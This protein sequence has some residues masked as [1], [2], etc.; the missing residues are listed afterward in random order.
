M[1]IDGTNPIL[2]Y[3]WGAAAADPSRLIQNLAESSKKD[4]QRG[5]F[6][7]MAGICWNPAAG[8]F[9]KPQIPQWSMEVW[10]QRC[11]TK[12][13]REMWE[14]DQKGDTTTKK[15]HIPEISWM[16]SDLL[17]NTHFLLEK[18]SRNSHFLLTPISAQIPGG[19]ND[20]SAGPVKNRMIL[21]SVSCLIP[22]NLPDRWP[23]VLALIFS[24]CRSCYLQLGF[25]FGL[26]CGTSLGSADGKVR[27]KNIFC[28]GIVQV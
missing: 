4:L 27:R 11:D 19:A 13:R 9:V 12:C 28:E 2:L 15:T 25:F 16:S 20:L 6:L 17:C 1:A 21:G 18:G 5:F 8:M 14:H 7:W 24:A 3:N 10:T 23:K 22:R 26:F